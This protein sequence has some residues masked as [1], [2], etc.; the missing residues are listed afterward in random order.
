MQIFVS[1]RMHWPMCQ[2]FL[3]I[4][5]HG[6]AQRLGYFH[7]CWLFYSI[8]RIMQI[9]IRPGYTPSASNTVPIDIVP[10]PQYTLVL[11]LLRSLFPVLSKWLVLL[12]SPHLAFSRLTS[13]TLHTALQSVYPTS[14]VRYC[15]VQTTLLLIGLIFVLS[16]GITE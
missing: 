13:P 10:P 9:S 8:C 4:G 2:A 3:L 12:F 16:N 1:R 6:R 15:T 7:R 14:A 5:H 11:P